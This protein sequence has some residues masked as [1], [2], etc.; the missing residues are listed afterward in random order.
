MYPLAGT[1]RRA[2]QL[3]MAQGRFLEP[4]LAQPFIDPRNIGRVFELLE[5]DQSFVAG[6]DPPNRFCTAPGFLDT[7][8]S[9]GGPD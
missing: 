8:L 4:R 3:L 7:S 5:S 1:C 6:I 9:C 2:E